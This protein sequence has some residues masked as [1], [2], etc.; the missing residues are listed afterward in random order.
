MNT[1]RIRLIKFC[2]ERKISSWMD[3]H[4]PDLREIQPL[5]FYDEVPKWPEGVEASFRLVDWWCH[6]VRPN[7]LL[8]LGFCGDKRSAIDLVA[9]V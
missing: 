7:F 5:S 1:F 3:V 6:E 9:V 2:A 8:P 4:A